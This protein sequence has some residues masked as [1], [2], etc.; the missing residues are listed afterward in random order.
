[1]KFR[2]F[3][4]EASKENHAVLAF[5]RM[6]PP[7]TGHEVL[8]KKVHDVAKE[9]GGSHHV[10]LSHS[11][12]A[13]K[14]PLSA[15]QKVKHAKRFFPKTNVSVSDKEHPNFL[16]QAAK[17][18]KQGVTHLHMVAGSD[19][20]EEYHKL[21]HKYNGTHKGALFNF[22][23]IKVHSAGERD[24]DA[25]GTTG[26]S[27]SKM[28]SHATTGNYKEFKKGIPA[29]VKDSHAKELYNDVR[30]NMGVKESID[31]QFTELLTEGVNDKSIF[32]AVFLAGG[33][34]SGK[35]YVLDNTLAGHGLIEIN[36]DKALEYLMD[37]EGL[38][39]LMPPE[40]E[41]K[42]N[43]VRGRAKNITSVRERLAILG[44]NGL[45][46]NGTGDDFEKNAKIKKRLEE[47]G[48]D[49]S[50]VLVNT[51]D[52]VSQQRNIER[53]TRGGRTVP[54]NIRKEKW[55]GVQAARTEYAKLFG[56]S[57]M[58]FD[59]SEDLRQADPEVVKQKKDE[60]MDI[61]KRIKDFTSQPPQTPQ[62]QAW[63]AGQMSEKDK[64]P[65]PTAGAEK[66]PPHGSAAAE[67]AKKMGLQYYGFGRYGKDGK[68]LYRSVN[69]RLV[70]IPKESPDKTIKNIPSIGSSDSNGKL[71]PAKQKRVEKA[72]ETSPLKKLSSAE[73]K[74]KG[75]N[76]EFHQFFSEAVTVSITGDTAAEVQS[77]FSMMNNEIETNENTMSDPTESLSL[78]KRLETIGQKADGM[79]ITNAD[80][81]SIFEESKV[82]LLRDVNGKIRIF[83]LRRA[84]AKE[85]HTKNGVVMK[86]PTSPGYVVKIHE[87]NED[88]KETFEFIQE[89][90]TSGIRTEAGRTSGSTSRSLTESTSAGTSASS[91]GETRKKI[92]FQEIR[93]QKEKILESIDK[94]IEPGL[95]MAGAGESLGRDTGEKIRRKT[96]KASQVDETIGD[97]GEMATSNSVE[98]ELEL[99]RK[100]ISLASFKAKK[101]AI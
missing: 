52:D 94:G 84:A 50:M 3:I 44:R 37:V 55:D 14:N 27:A 70:E 31:E 15:E 68:T 17:L 69:D 34:G 42:R 59:N 30:K 19:R 60:M 92:T 7:T 96:G 88:A 74:V 71:N 25:E 54:E 33:P 98:K 90:R 46:I 9:V 81:A 64:Q 100:G 89:A 97:G 13:A 20:T 91:Q 67:E 49:T 65:I 11:Q 21:L 43:L 61:F 41:E 47:L 57:Y 45:I 76:E 66:L 86:H 80:M 93:K 10:V 29:H 53:G 8:V 4:T 51:G 6:N 12:D 87:E 101:G 79:V 32:K 2:D 63:I 40:E 58:E 62:A 23:H 35:D 18:H 77:M 1:M 56:D 99:K 75:V 83:M 82:K 26:M 24:P 22:K 38:S 5:G 48:Y 95:S 16:T 73:K 72:K 78:G 28:R 36:S 39:S 85:A